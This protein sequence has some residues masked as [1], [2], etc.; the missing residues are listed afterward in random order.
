MAFNSSYPGP[1]TQPSIDFGT[2]TP[3]VPF[4]DYTVSVIDTCGKTTTTQF[5]VVAIPPMPTI[6]GT[7]NGCSSNSGNIEARIPLYMIV[8]AVVTVAPAS[9]PFTLPHNVTASLTSE[10]VLILDPMPIGD[11]TI[12][13]TDNCGD[14]L[15]PLT[16]TIP[17]YIS[18][19]T[20]IE[21]LPG[22]DIDRATVRIK[23]DNGRLTSVKITAAP[24]GFPFPLPYDISNN[25]ISSGI[26]YMTGLPTGN[27]TFSI[28]DNCGIITNQS[29]TIEGYAITTNNFS[30]TANCGSFNI[31]LDFV[32]NVSADEAF[33][34]QRLLDPAT[35]TW[36]NPVTGAVYT[37]G[38]K[39]TETN[40]Y[41]LQNNAT[42]FNLTFN[43][44]FRIVH[45][46]RSYNSGNE[47]NSGVVTSA[48]KSCIEILSPTLSFNNA[49]SINDILRVP[50]SE[51]GNL[52]VLL[53][54][55]GTPP[56]HYRIIEKDGLPF[57]LDNGTSAVFLDIAPGIYKFEVEDSCGNTVNRTFDVSDLASLVTIFPMCDLFNCTATITGNE[58]FDLSQ[59]SVVI[60]GDQS[61]SDYT[62]SYYTSQADVASNTNPIT[63]LTTY[64]PAANPQTIYVRLTFNQLPNCYESASFNLITGQTPGINLTPEYIICDS[65]PI[66]LD[67][68]SGN[69]PITTYLW[70]TGAATPSITV[71]NVGTTTISVTATNIYG[72]CNNAS[73]A[74]TKSKDIAVTIAVLPEI[75]HIEFE[76]WTD[77]ENSITVVTTQPGAFE[78]S[79]DGITF[80]NSPTFTGLKP[81]LYTVFVRDISGCKTVIEEI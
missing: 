62:L 22:C 58:T 49:L 37:E 50:C 79:L 55:N 42:N 28:I 23:S 35:N 6:I 4:G 48:T 59:Q 21:V 67:A 2:G 80:Q 71:S 64:S 76:D 26:L 7:N 15:N 68:S 57:T 33:G 72:S 51:N 9:Y 14:I 61:P 16:V 44:V 18:Q 74:C 29:E 36:G 73:L 17:A 25:I 52:D 1:F 39:I 11:Y 56:L 8:S 5:S 31:P 20:T 3:A 46:F 70:S 24:A 32:D 77:N 12:E 38:T 40:S 19:G 34:L 30:L 78:Y 54:T 27:Y 10:G 47:I 13:I 53:F 63:N 75:D 66:V 43:G 81:G 41:L 45:Y 65:Q 60:L 69:L